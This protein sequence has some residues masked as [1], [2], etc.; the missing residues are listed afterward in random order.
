[1]KNFT[2]KLLAAA[3]VGGTLASA[4]VPTLPSINTAN[5][6]NVTNYG[7]V[8]DGV[9]T[10]TTAI[11]NAINAATAAASNFTVKFFMELSDKLT[12][13]AGSSTQS[14]SFTSASMIWSGF[15]TCLKVEL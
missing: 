14:T 5:I 10:N 13:F 12:H 15:L 8:G 11:Q 2:V 1:M 7:A 9:T 4:S 6:F 3:V